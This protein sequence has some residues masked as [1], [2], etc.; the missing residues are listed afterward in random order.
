[1]RVASYAMNNLNRG[2]SLSSPYGFRDGLLLENRYYLGNADIFD[3]GRLSFLSL[4]Y[5]PS[6]G[7]AAGDGTEFHP[8]LY[9]RAYLTYDIKPLRSYLYFDGTYT[10]ERLMKAR[11]L[12]M[13]IGVAARPFMRLQNLEFRL[14]YDLTGDVQADTTRNLLYGAVRINY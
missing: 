13:D 4:G 9:A 3:V 12:E 8:G 11:L 2:N 14:G 1:L 5:F 7:M 6:K 10:G